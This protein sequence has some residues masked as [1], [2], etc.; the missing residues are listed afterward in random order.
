[1]KDLIGFAYRM[2]TSQVLGPDWLASE[3][4]E[5]AA[6]LPAGSTPA[7]VPEMMQAL[8]AERLQMKVHREKKEF[9]VYVLEIGKG[10]PKLQES[11]PDPDG[12]DTADKGTEIAVSGSSQGVSANLGRGSS[13]SFTNNRLEAKKL[14]MAQLVNVL[15]RFLDRPIVAMTNLK[16]RYDFALNIT[17]EDYRAMMVRAALASGV[18]LPPAALRALDNGS[19]VSLFSAFEKLGLRLD[20][21]KAPLDM[22]VVDEVR[23]TPVEN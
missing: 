8:L 12:G 21:R 4:F 10:G 2:K 20:G 9:P 18:I 19:P 23:K 6:T 13:Y 14:A 16:G 3:I 5:I 15:E 22:I 17:E 11:P 1:M 7:Q